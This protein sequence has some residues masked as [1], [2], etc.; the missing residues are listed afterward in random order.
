VNSPWQNPL[1]TGEGTKNQVVI[2]FYSDFWI[3]ITNFCLSEAIALYQK[4][5]F[6]GKEIVVFPTGLDLE[7]KNI[8]LTKSSRWQDEICLNQFK[9]QHCLQSISTFH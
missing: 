8:L 6:K 4:A 2:Y 1:P 3:P 5:L 7:T 9:E